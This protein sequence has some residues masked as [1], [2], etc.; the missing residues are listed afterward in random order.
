MEI[1]WNYMEI[2]GNIWKL[3]GNIWKCWLT[4]IYW[5]VVWNMFS[6]SGN[7]LD[8]AIENGPVKI[9]DVPTFIAW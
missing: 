2:Y 1:I 4:N 7:L 9:V 6:F 3:Y 8:F 5:L